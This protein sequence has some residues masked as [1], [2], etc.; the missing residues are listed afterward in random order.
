MVVVWGTLS[1]LAHLSRMG[2]VE[3]DEC[4]ACG[5]SETLEHYLCHCPASQKYDPDMLGVIPFR[6]ICWRKLRSFISTGLHCYTDGL[7]A[8]IGRITELYFSPSRLLQFAGGS[9]DENRLF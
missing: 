6:V 7:G 9:L 4:R 1:V 8:Y 5:M 3:G 2:V